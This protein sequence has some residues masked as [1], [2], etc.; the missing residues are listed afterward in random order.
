MWYNLAMQK[1]AKFKPSKYAIW[2]YDVDKMDF[3][4]P[5]V[6]KWYLERKIDYNDWKGIKYEHL[7]KYL[8]E[9][10]IDAGKRE[11]LEDFVR[12]KEEELKKNK[13]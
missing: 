4:S 1:S 3:S 12:R 11:M 10:N 5:V 8:P 9:L 13:K 7:K 6:L 2:D